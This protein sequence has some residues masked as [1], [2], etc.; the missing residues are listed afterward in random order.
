MKQLSVEGMSKAKNFVNVVMF[1]GA[2]LC[3]VLGG[4]QIAIATALTVVM[5][6]LRFIADD[7]REVLLVIQ[8]VVL[9]FFVDSMLIRS[10]V[11][12]LSNDVLIP[13]V[14]L[15]CLWIVFSTLLNHS[16][17]WLQSQLFIAVLLGGLMAPFSY[18][19]G[20]RL[21]NVSLAEP[22]AW[23]L[24]F[25]AVAWAVAFPMCLWLAQR[26]AERFNE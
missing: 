6:H 24:G 23:S 16:L 13:P 2:W 19:A 26:A 12:V 8:V 7:W 17:R 18:Y 21:T 11:I 1:N 4:N 5:L 22:E 9:G 25:V 14:W 3:C 15:I 10:G 20:I